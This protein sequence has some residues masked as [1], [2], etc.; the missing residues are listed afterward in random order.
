MYTSVPSQLQQWLV[1]IKL[2][3]VNAPYF[4]QAHLLIAA[5]CTAFAYGN[6]HADFIKIKSVSLDVLN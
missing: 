1:Q 4:Q 5:D 2:A 3:P 6:F